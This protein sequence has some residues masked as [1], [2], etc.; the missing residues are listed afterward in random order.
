MEKPRFKERR[1]S[2]KAAGWKGEA[3]HLLNTRSRPCG[4]GGGGSTKRPKRKESHT[5]AQKL[6]Q[7]T[8]DTSMTQ[9][10]QTFSYEQSMKSS[11]LTFGGQDPTDSR[12]KFISI[13][14][15]RAEERF[16]EIFRN[17]PFVK[18]KDEQF[19][20]FKT[21]DVLKFDIY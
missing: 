11:L 7:L 3:V 2:W 6:S 20:S 14:G 21:Q 13:S 17:L 5:R 4:G 18:R 12:A 15:G 10:R 16:S 19:Q 1:A 8:A 9:S